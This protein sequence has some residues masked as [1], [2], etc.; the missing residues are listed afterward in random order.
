[1]DQDELENLLRENI[2]IS[3]ANNKI[4]RKI[5]GHI[6][7]SQ[8]FRLF[9]WTLILGSALGLYYFIQPFIDNVREIVS[10]PSGTLNNLLPSI[11]GT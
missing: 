5:H 6:R 8:A 1:M 3:R 7:W 10:D 2:E 9:Y 4:L 11:F